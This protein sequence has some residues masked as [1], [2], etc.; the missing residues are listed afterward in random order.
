MIKNNTLLVLGAGASM[1]YNFPSGADLRREIIARLTESSP[2]ATSLN[3]LT[4]AS[5]A[6]IQ[7]FRNDFHLSNIISIDAFLAMRPEY[8]KLGKYAI[9]SIL[10]IYENQNTLFSPDIEDDW[11]SL[12]WNKLRFGAHTI[13]DFKENKLNVITFNYDRSLEHYLT[14]SIQHSYNISYEEAI[15]V[16]N[17]AISIIHVYGKLGDLD[18]RNKQSFRPYAPQW[19]AIYADAAVQSLRIIPESRND[20]LVFDE[21]KKLYDK[22]SICFF[23][24]F[25]FDPLNIERLGF[26]SVIKSK[27]NASWAARMILSGY[28][29]TE[30]EMQISCKE[31]VGKENPFLPKI[32]YD[33]TCMTLRNNAGSLS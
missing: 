33:K 21:C 3:K 12:L 17:D 28:G 27:P 16:L 31:I 29:R 22:S 1:A 24:G 11:Y 10:H 8:S 19:T 7:A 2:F 20:D 13:E 9:A 25:G 23:L 32:S 4:R 6:E 15:D 26:E 18:R 14:T 5:H 30:Q